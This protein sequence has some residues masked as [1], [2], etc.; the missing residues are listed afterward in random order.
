MKSCSWQ[1][2]IETDIAGSTYQNSQDADTLL[3]P[4][5]LKRESSFDGYCSWLVPR[6]GLEHAREPASVLAT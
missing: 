2:Y 6:T 4:L 3:S 1:E 5:A